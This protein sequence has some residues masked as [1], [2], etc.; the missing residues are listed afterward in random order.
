MTFF[1]QAS[2]QH[3]TQKIPRKNLIYKFLTLTVIFIRLCSPLALCQT[4]AYE[5]SAK[6]NTQIAPLE[7][8]SLPF[9]FLA[10]EPKNLKPFADTTLEGINHFDPVRQPLY[11]HG[12]LGTMGSAHWPIIYQ[13]EF[14]RGFDMG[15]RQF[16]HYQ[17]HPDS[18][19]FYKLQYAWS[20]IA[21]NQG[22]EQEDANIKAIFSRNFGPNTNFTIQYDRLLYIPLSATKFQN[23]RARNVAFAS[24]LWY[25]NPQSGYQTG[26]SFIRNSIEQ[27]DNGGVTSDSLFNPNLFQSEIS[28]PVFLA[29]A[30]TRFVNNNLNFHQYLPLFNTP[31]SIST[32]QLLIHHHLDFEQNLYKFYDNLNGTPTNSLPAT[33]SLFYQDLLI[34]IRG[35]RQYHKWRKIENT[36]SLNWEIPEKV[37]VKAGLL[38]R[39]VRISQETGQQTINNLMVI[40]D[41]RF[42][43]SKTTSLL[44]S[45]HL[46]L[47][48][49]A[50][51]YRIK[52]MLSIRNNSFVRLNATFIQELFSP[53]F[54]KQEMVV[55]Q[56]PVWT[57]AFKAT[58][59]TETNVQLHF[60]SL[61]LS[62]SAAYHRLQNLIFF[63]YSS[64]PEQSEES[65]TLFQTFLRN[66]FKIGPLGNENL[67]V[68]QFT[69]QSKQLPLPRFYTQNSLFLE[70]WVFKKAMLARIG[71]N[72]RLVSGFNPYKYQPL[73]G[74][75]YL[76][77]DFTTN[78]SPIAD[79]FL[80]I[81]VSDFRFFFRFDNLS[82]TLLNQRYY[83]SANHPLLNSYMRFGF[84]WL[85]KN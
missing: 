83:L 62:L 42:D 75:F 74:A 54:I 10:S 38:H 17:I 21:Y 78:L 58:A 33:D 4:Y 80:S 37:I 65:T 19:R 48:D 6:V 1:F 64:L 20:E 8:T 3:D 82:A 5:D 45:M 31:D 30:Q 41:A 36:L 46:G 69:P 73:T 2:I 52:A 57:N 26:F 12:N 81:K 77:D 67:F 40:G 53:D 55:N 18:F 44:T 16:N 43:F 13:R 7:N 59:A 29:D 63:N 24:G 72:L 22:S 28:T 84:R 49:N 70:G 66:R 76:Q 23:Q 32:N 68:F 50:G 11:S 71:L 61:S 15:W 25:E 79:A 56:Q 34:D 39:N 35:M 60:P 9:L 27:K 47:W 14:R 51:D 85:L